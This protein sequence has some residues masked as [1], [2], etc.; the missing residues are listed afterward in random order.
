MNRSPFHKSR[1]A[2][3]PGPIVAVAAVTLALL[4]FERNT[5]VDARATLESL[6]QLREAVAE[7]LPRPSPEQ[8]AAAR[9]NRSNVIP[10]ASR[11]GGQALRDRVVAC[12]TVEGNPVSSL[13][14]HEDNPR[15][16]ALEGFM[17]RDKR[18]RHTRPWRAYRRAERARRDV[19]VQRPLLV[20]L[21][22][23]T[24]RTDFTKPWLGPVR[25]D[26][27]GFPTSK[28]K[29]AEQVFGKNFDHRDPASVAGFYYRES[30]GK[31]IIRGDQSSIHTVTVPHITFTFP[32]MVEAILAQLDPVVDF[33]KRADE[34]GW[35]DPIFVMTPFSLTH[36]VYDP[37]IMGENLYLG[38]GPHLYDLAPALTDDVYP[39]GSHAAL[40]T[41]AVSMVGLA[42]GANTDPD[43]S[44]FGITDEQARHDF[45]ALYAHEYGHAIGLSHM[46]TMDYGLDADT[47]TSDPRFIDT[48]FFP[49]SLNRSWASGFVSTIMN[50]AYGSGRS[51]RFLPD[52]GRHEAGLDAINRAKLRWGNITEITLAADGRPRRD[53]LGPGGRQRVDLVEHLGHGAFDPR[54]Q[55]LKINLPPKEV[56][57]FPSRD[58]NGA[59]TT[60]WRPGASS[61]RMVWSG[62]TYGGTRTMETTLRIP[63]DLAQPV[64][65]FWTKYGAQTG[66]LYPLGFEYGWVQ[67]STDG[68]TTWTSLPGLTTSTYTPP[69][70]ESVDWVGEDLGAPA[71]TG[72]SRVYSPDGWIFEQVALP[73]AAGSSVRV[74]FNFGGAGFCNGKPA[75]DCGWWIDDVY[76]GTSGDPRRILVSDFEDEDAHRWRGLLTEFDRGFGFVVVEET[77]PFP[78]A[79]FFELRGNND[80]DDVAFKAMHPKNINGR[81]DSGIYR[82]DDGVVGY[83]ADQ[84]ASFWTNPHLLAGSATNT[85]VP[86][87]R[88]RRAEISY[89]YY[90][91]AY[92]GAVYDFGG[93]LAAAF[94]PASGVTLDDVVFAFTLPSEVFDLADAGPGFSLPVVGRFSELSTI[95]LLDASPTYRPFDVEPS[96]P[97]TPLPGRPHNLWAYVL[98]APGGW[99]KSIKHGLLGL[100]D[101]TTVRVL[102]QPFL[103]RDAAF[104]PDRNARF[105]DRLDYRGFFREE[106]SN[107][108]AGSTE[109]AFGSRARSDRL[110]L[111]P[112][113]A[114]PISP[115]DS[116]PKYALTYCPQSASGICVG[117]SQAVE[118]PWLEQVMYQRLE[119]LVLY[120]ILGSC[121][122]EPVGHTSATKP[123]W[124]AYY[125]CLANVVENTHQFTTE[126]VRVATRLGDNPN[127]AGLN[128]FGSQGTLSPVLWKEFYLDVWARAKAPAPL[129]SV[130]LSVDVERIAPGR[131]PVATLT[132]RRAGQ[133]PRQLTSR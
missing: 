125:A 32:P 21:E 24:E 109:A 54:S 112:D 45:P 38:Y 41:L 36:D 16:S 115:T 89:P 1:P 78:Q 48:R 10:G 110:V 65:G 122:A 98:G 106:F 68:G 14:A 5:S 81:R 63:R 35:V 93:S 39:D 28:K 96:V 15:A 37:S 59:A 87:S 6:A 107:W 116:I 76:L 12:P 51:P 27:P 94:D 25:F 79:Y 130:G 56:A 103:A 55:I 69:G 83:F 131:T 58:S 114:V 43:D 29:I 40:S 62:R 53:E 108:H 19:D 23:P 113:A 92:Q 22:T 70:S 4:A 26:R 85:H 75:Q 132:I 74:R 100:N 34:F 17:L 60:Y 57:L 118:R 7:R 101:P 119:P 123:L 46:M 52:D 126:L 120:L 128:A 88:L 124:A 129:P 91:Q 61:K 42:F 95:S 127:Y 90:P 82:Y 33:T 31:L 13:I 9:T 84:Y 111:V 3:G 99:P 105:D 80:H 67:I 86:I 71:L 73:V 117:P 11:L 64:L 66:Y 104:H 121:P 30:G 77:T 18:G 47:T 44:W 50:Y 133:P 2:F 8:L 72:D 102:G 97:E 49:S 20:F